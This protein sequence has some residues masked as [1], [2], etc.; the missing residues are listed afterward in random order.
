MGT[1]NMIHREILGYFNRKFL[2]YNCIMNK[3][4]LENH[5]LFDQ[6]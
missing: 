2:L 3:S 5:I 4:F 1:K 6:T